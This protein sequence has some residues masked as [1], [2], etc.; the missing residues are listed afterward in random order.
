[1]ADVLLER[2]VSPRDLTAGGVAS[3]RAALDDEAARGLL[4]G[5]LD[6]QAGGVGEMAELDQGAVLAANEHQHARSTDRYADGH[7]YTCPAN[8]HACAADEYQYTRSANEHQHVRST[9]R[10]THGDQHLHSANQHPNGY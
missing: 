1:M 9:D 3:M 5:D 7:E 10:Y 8:G 4:P 6:H 2:C